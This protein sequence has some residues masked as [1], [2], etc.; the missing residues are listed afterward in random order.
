MHIHVVRSLGPLPR[1]LTEFLIGGEDGGVVW[2]NERYEHCVPIHNRTMCCLLSESDLQ[3]VASVNA[4]PRKLL[5][6]FCG[7]PLEMVPK[8]KE[9][10]S[11]GNSNFFC[12]A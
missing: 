3:A 10:G 9:E 2:S 7:K 11:F 12:L 1:D 6:C 4:K 5:I 8:S